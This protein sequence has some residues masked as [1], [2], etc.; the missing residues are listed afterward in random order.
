[1]PDEQADAQTPG[2]A[3]SPTGAQSPEGARWPDGDGGLRQQRAAQIRA[4]EEQAQRE[5]ETQQESTE[6]ATEGTR[7]T[8]PVGQGERVVRDGE[9]ISSIAREAG[10]FWETVWNDGANSGLREVR[11][12][13]NILL[14]G[15]RV[16]VPEIRPKQE[17]GETEMRHRF[18]LRGEPTD[19]RVRV[20]DD[21]QPRASQPYTVEVG[22]REYTGTTDADGWLT[23]PI[24]GDARLA[25]LTIGPD[26]A[27]IPLQLGE[28]DPVE[29]IRGVQDRLDNL[30]FDCDGERGELGDGTREALRAF[31]ERFELEVT[32]EPDEA[33]RSRLVQEHGV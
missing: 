9:C 14:P 26:D 1:M 33:T 30:G 19:I 13:P 18:V 24:P 12:D 7:A 32:G 8:G 6:E 3:Q 22:D 2:E 25:T 10:H 16:H 11:G 17:P 28:L 15:D 27:V 5:A 21:D 20:M 29:E 4:E 31:Q 23:V